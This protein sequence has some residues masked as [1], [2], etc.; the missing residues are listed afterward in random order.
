MESESITIEMIDKTKE[1][2]KEYGPVPE[3]VLSD[4]QTQLLSCVVCFENSCRC[5]FK[6]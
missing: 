6:N 4:K 3:F 5:K 2:I 1:N